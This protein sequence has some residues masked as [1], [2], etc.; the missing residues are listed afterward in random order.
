M[1]IT[2]IDAALAATAPTSDSQ[3]TLTLQ[4]GPFLDFV[5]AHPWLA[6]AFLLIVVVV[7]PAVWLPSRHA[8]AMAV[9][10]AVVGAVSAAAVAVVAFVVALFRP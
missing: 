5:A 8:A 10:H 2:N 4:L 1:T 6:I 3:P 9:I 7:V